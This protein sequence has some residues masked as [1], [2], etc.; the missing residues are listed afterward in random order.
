[1]IATT[2]LDAILLDVGG[3]FYLPDPDRIVA[4]ARRHE[5][6]VDADALPRAHFTACA[7]MT[8]FDEGDAAIWTEYQRSYARSLG[9]P[10]DREDD[11]IDVL[12]TEFAIAG[13]W[14]WIIPGSVAALGRLAALGLPMAIVSNSDGTAAIRLREDEICQVGPGPGVELHAIVDSGLVGVAKPDPAIFRI[15]L[16]AL[17][18]DAARTI[19]VGD[20]P[21]ADVVGARA[22]GIEPV[23]LDP[24]DLCAHVACTRVA[25]LADV[26]DLVR[27]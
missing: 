7:S 21:A 14:R 4:A 2:E 25:S 16:E 19:Y 8:Q 26:V 9:I 23:L 17:G 5:L 12:M 22:A 20:T 3:V 27:A 11:A 24:Y 13:M 10:R 18:V 6:E 15:A 1:M